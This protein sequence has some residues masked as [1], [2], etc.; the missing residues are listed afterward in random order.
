MSR[1]K[2]KAMCLERV[3]GQK[4]LH[5]HGVDVAEDCEGTDHERNQCSSV[6]SAEAMTAPSDSEVAI[7]G[8]SEGLEILEEV[9]PSEP[10]AAVKGSTEIQGG[11]PLNLIYLLN[12]LAEM[13]F[14]PNCCVALHIYC[15]LPVTVTQAEQPFSVL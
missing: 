2:K 13:G 7:E 15:T 4:S 14:L 11:K 10:D 5:Q 8:L 1:N 3:K 9:P 6:P 12:T